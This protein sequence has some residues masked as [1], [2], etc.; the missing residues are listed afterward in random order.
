MHGSGG[1][2][3]FGSVVCPFFFPYLVSSLTSSLFFC[4]K[5]ESVTSTPIQYTL[6]DNSTGFWKV[7]APTWSLQNE[8]MPTSFGNAIMD[9]GSFSEEI[10]LMPLMLT[11]YY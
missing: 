10:S 1:F 2:Y 8:E 4:L 3:T 11:L 5:D 7:A 9:T 6:V